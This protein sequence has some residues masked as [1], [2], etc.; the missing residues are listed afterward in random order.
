MA[1]PPTR[2]RLAAGDGPD[3]WHLGRGTDQ[4][5][6]PA[7]RVAG[8]RIVHSGTLPGRSTGAPPG[9]S[10]RAHSSSTAVGE[11]TYSSTL[12]A[13]TASKRGRRERQRPPVA[14][15]AARTRR[16]P[17]DRRPRPDPAYWPRCRNRSPAARRRPDAGPVPG[18]AAESS[19]RPPAGTWYP[20]TSASCVSRP[21]SRP[22]G[23][24]L[25]AR[26]P[27]FASKSCRTFSGV[28]QRLVSH[29]RSIRRRHGSWRASWPAWPRLAGR[30]RPPRRRGTRPRTRGAPCPDA[31]SRP[32]YR[33]PRPTG[34]R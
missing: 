26:L 23:A 9:R 28:G 16:R 10:T 25:A 13:T 1:V 24:Y 29:D 32:S 7:K 2:T 30:S 22:C 6:Q 5:L 34:S 17:R 27:A 11:P 20:A 33:P 18:A 31:P 3:R 14:A 8:S 19:T 12:A 21:D 15:A 4:P